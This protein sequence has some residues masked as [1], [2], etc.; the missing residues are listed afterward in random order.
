MAGARGRSP[1]RSHK[2]LAPTCSPHSKNPTSPIMCLMAFPFLCCI[3][4]P[5]QVAV[6]R[7]QRERQPGVELL[8]HSLTPILGPPSPCSSF[9]KGWLS[10]GLLAEQ[11]ASQSLA[12]GELDGGDPLLWPRSTLLRGKARCRP[13]LQVSKTRLRVD[14][15]VPGCDCIM[16]PM[17]LAR[18]IP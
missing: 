3:P 10:E 13:I 15:E 8:G 6:C 5:R 11:M 12:H 7:P 18:H 4:G 1:R 2:C 9:H 14:H 17:S 16:K